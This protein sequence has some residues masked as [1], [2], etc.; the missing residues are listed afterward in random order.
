MYGGEG[1]SHV[2]LDPRPLE[3]GRSGERPPPR[4]GRVLR[5]PRAHAHHHRHLPY[6]PHRPTRHFY[7]GR[8]IVRGRRRLLTPTLSM[9]SVRKLRHNRLANGHGRR[10]ILS[11]T[12]AVSRITSTQ[13]LG[14]MMAKRKITRCRR[15]PRS[16]MVPPYTSIY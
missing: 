3:M 8:V 9:L 16:Q 4:V 13:G 2:P 10:L 14:S 5:P 7:P 6:L 12:E 11:E 15:L 1:G